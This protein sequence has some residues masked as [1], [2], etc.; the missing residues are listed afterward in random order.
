MYFKI[1]GLLS[2]V[3]SLL[4]TSFPPLSQNEVNFLLDKVSISI[5]VLNPI[6]YCP[7]QGLA[8]VPPFSPVPLTLCFYL[9]P[10]LSSINIVKFVLSTKKLPFDFYFP[11]GPNTE[12]S[13]VLKVDKYQH[14]KILLHAIS[15]K[16]KFLCVHTHTTYT[17]EVVKITHDAIG[18]LLSIAKQQ[19]IMQLAI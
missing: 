9:L 10:P 17:K 4:L 2:W 18:F 8:K 11:S 1:N 12:L 5:C 6:H 15:I 16:E 7:T 3:T 19:I 13:I 14:H